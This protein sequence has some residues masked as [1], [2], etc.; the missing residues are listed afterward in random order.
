M[1]TPA[2]DRYVQTE[3]GGV[4]RSEAKLVLPK[5][6]NLAKSRRDMSPGDDSRGDL[7]TRESKSNRGRL[8]NREVLSILMRKAKS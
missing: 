5:I 1:S 6:K 8:A 3:K 7:M 2:T 4:N